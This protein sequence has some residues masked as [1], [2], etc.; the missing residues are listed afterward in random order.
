MATITCE[1]EHLRLIQNALDLYSRIGIL[2]LDNILEHPSLEQ[3]LLNQF[4]SKEPLKVDSETN[5]GKI[6]EMGEGYIK[7]K[8]CWCDWKDRHTEEEIKK[9]LEENPS[10]WVEEI[11][12]WTDI[13][14]IKNKTDYGKYH[15]T[16]DIIKEKLNDVKNLIANDGNILSKNASYGLYRENEGKHNI[17]AF[18]MIQ[19]IRHEFWKQNPNRSDIT[20]DSSVHC[21]GGSLPEIKVEL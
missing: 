15:E 12:T 6:V 14:K 16:R 3:M 11:R 7:T 1:K 4:S 20:V 13:E 5:R 2:Q 9:L 18:N 21:F 8:S 17:D 19:I 10:G